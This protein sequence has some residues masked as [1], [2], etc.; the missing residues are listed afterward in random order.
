[1]C[2]FHLGISRDRLVI[3]EDLEAVVTNL[4]NEMP[5]LVKAVG[6]RLD[7]LGTVGALLV[8]EFMERLNAAEV[9]VVASHAAQKLGAGLGNQRADLPSISAAQCPGSPSPSV[10]PSVRG[11]RERE[12]ERE[13]GV[14]GGSFRVWRAGVNS[15]CCCWWW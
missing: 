12:R 7:Q 9:E 10:S 5:G 2:G 13:R 14:I 11:Q 15:V 1:M 6:P 4:S 3:V 8:D